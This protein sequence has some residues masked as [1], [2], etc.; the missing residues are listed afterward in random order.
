[1]EQTFSLYA[2]HING[3][4]WST[5]QQIFLRAGTPREI[6]RQL[7]GYYQDDPTTSLKA[8]DQIELIGYQGIQADGR[9]ES[10]RKVLAKFTGSEFLGAAYAAR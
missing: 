4:S 5:K 2:I 8:D 3:E 1:M 10:C 7:M 6:A 9:T